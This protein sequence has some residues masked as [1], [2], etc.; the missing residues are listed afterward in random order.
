MCDSGM[1]DDVV[2]IVA[3]VTISREYIWGAMKFRLLVS[4]I[5]FVVSAITVMFAFAQGNPHGRR[6]EPLR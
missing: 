3:S 5:G 1:D 2:L 4:A 6:G